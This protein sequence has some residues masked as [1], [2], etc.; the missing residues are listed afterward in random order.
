MEKNEKIKVNRENIAKH[1]L[2]YQLSMVGKTMLIL[3]DDPYYK[4]NI[5]MTRGQLAQFKEYSIPLLQKV[6][7]FNKKKAEDT[8]AFFRK[9]FGL[10]IKN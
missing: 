6:F 4:F 3:I 9:E 8:F 1:L 2:E 7:H 5:T 10:R